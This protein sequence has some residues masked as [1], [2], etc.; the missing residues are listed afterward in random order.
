MLPG[1]G[2]LG[3]TNPITSRLQEATAQMLDLGECKVRTNDAVTFRQLCSDPVTGMSVCPVR[4]QFR[5][6]RDIAC[7][8]GKRKDILDNANS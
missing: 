3:N 6:I 8:T 1:W 2:Q 5:R 7:C 4:P